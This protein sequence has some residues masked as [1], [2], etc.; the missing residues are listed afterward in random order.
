MNRCHNFPSR[1]T[2]QTLS[3]PRVAHSAEPTPLHELHASFDSTKTA[4]TKKANMKIKILLHFIRVWVVLL[5]TMTSAHAQGLVNFNNL[6]PNVLRAPIYGP[7]LGN[8]TLVKFGNPATGVPAGSVV[9]TGPLLAGTGFTAELL[10][11]PAQQP[12]PAW[13]LR[14]HCL[15]RN[16]G[17]GALQWLIEASIRR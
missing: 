11:G 17:S 10:A 13:G 6:V 2:R 1:P 4:A 3:L 5:S 16:P 14:S 7:E 8:P 15:L 12:L 9:Y